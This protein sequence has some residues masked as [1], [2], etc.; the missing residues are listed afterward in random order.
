MSFKPTGIMPALVTPFTDDAKEIDEGRLRRLVNYVIAKGAT[1]VVPCGTT[2]E[3][4]NLSFEERKKVVE[5]VIDEVKG[6]V[7]VI[8]GTGCSGTDLTIE[9]T[10]HAKEAG[11]QAALIVTP[12]YHKPTNRGIYEHY[13]SVAEAVDIPIILYNIPQ[14]TGVTLPW[15]IVE[16]LVDIPNIVAVKDS[17]GELK[18]ILAV[19]EKTRPRL[20]VLCGHDEVVLPALAA[21]C[22]GAILASGNII[23]DIWMQ[24]YKAVNKGDLKRAQELQLKV[25]KICRII[26]KSGSV[27]VKAGLNMIGVPVGP[28]RLPLS[29]GGELSYEEMEE[30]RIDLEKIGKIER[31]VV[32][33]EVVPGKPIQERFAAIGITPQTIKDFSLRFGEALAGE[34]PEVAH[35]DLMVGMKAGPVGEAFA[36]A[37]ASP[38]PGHEPLVAILEPN[39]TV[40]PLTLIVPTVMIKS[41]RQASMIYGPAQTAVAKAVIDSVSDGILP[42]DAADDLILIANVFVHPAAVDRKRVYMNNYKAM[43]HS[44]RK[45][46]EG[47]PTI[48][49]LLEN[50]ERARHPFRYTP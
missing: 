40:K 30:L 34:E 39:L 27:G 45:A 31:K 47:R 38:T 32:T 3:F 49:D 26:V 37:K 13:R 18:G 1:G 46:M 43:R 22:S 6:R 9:I 41:M 25:Q 28:V 44:I 48:D 50:K 15:Q 4:Q 36:K 16:D 7:P 19:L 23:V 29:I 14:V 8:A 35:I 24:V 11:A 17:S 42:E 12:Y 33:V 5:I 20:S 2:G 10:R 21:G